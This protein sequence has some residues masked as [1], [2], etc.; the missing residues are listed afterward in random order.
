MFLWDD[1]LKYDLIS[2]TLCHLF[3]NKHTTLIIKGGMYICFWF[4][5]WICRENRGRQVI[6]DPVDVLTDWASGQILINGINAA[7]IGLHDFRSKITIL[8]Q[9]CIIFLNRLNLCTSSYFFFQEVFDL[10]SFLSKAYR[11]FLP[12]RRV[13][14]CTFIVIK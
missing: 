9:V 3:I 8:P 12:I 5:G 4:S 14:E 13:Y 7:E 10:S 2:I 6:V 1:Y 11:I